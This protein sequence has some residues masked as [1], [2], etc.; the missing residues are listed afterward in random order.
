MSMLIEEYITLKLT[1]E[2]LHSD[3]LILVNQDNEFKQRG[4]NLL[5]IDKLYFGIYGEQPIYI[6]QEINKPL[7]KLIDFINA[8][9]KLVA[10]SGYRS[11]EEQ[12]EIYNNSILENG[13]EFTQKYVARPRESEHQTGLSIDVTNERRNFTKKCKEAKWLASNAYKFG[14]ILRYPKGKEY[15]TGTSYEPWHIRY[16]GKKAAKEIFQNRITLEEYLKN[17]LTRKESNRAVV[18]VINY[19]E[20]IPQSDIPFIFDRFYRVEK[21]RNRNDGGSGLG[22]DITKN[23]IEAHG[24]RI[25]VKSDNNRTLFKVILLLD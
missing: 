2:D 6:S 16:V 23:L 20:P 21:S 11:E 13:I 14:F 24:G 25:L 19:G 1:E 15:I 3:N 9:K 7:L 10:V 22:L 12:E 4:V 5:P 17:K 8:K 18:E